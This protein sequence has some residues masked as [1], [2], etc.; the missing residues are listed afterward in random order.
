MLLVV[1]T[2]T[3]ASL[4]VLRRTL[5]DHAGNRLLTLS[6]QFG[7]TF[8]ASTAGS[9]S[10]QLALAKEP[11]IAAYLETPT[12]AS[13]EQALAALAP[14][15]LQPELTLLVELR[16]R[17]GRVDL[18][19]PNAPESPGV[20]G[21]AY[22]AGWAD[23]IAAVSSA[24]PRTYLG[25]FQQSGD[26]TF[27]P[28]VAMIPGHDDAFVVS[29]RRVGTGAQSRAQL[30]KILGTE[31]ALYFG[32]ADDTVWNQTGALVAA[33]APSR[34]GQIFDFDRGQERMIAVRNLIDG[35][36]WAYAIEFPLRVV[37]APAR[38]FLWTM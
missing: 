5:H 9:K 24:T 25:K 10:R 7:E 22:D 19:R 36:P 31:A 16:R 3:T 28:A 15:G 6:D 35:T 38:D 29:W 4:V 2:L 12:A 1:G 18:S 27:Y 30:A 17:D 8:N 32:N 13:R 33:P 11:A 14:T 20:L 34:P 37:E 23:V 26:V 21:P